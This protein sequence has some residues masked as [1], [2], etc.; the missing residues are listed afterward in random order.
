MEKPIIY[1]ER[2]MNRYV[3]IGVQTQ[4]DKNVEKN[5]GKG[6]VNFRGQQFLIPLFF[7]KTNLKTEI[8]GSERFS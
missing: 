7:A 5:F 4:T 2:D 8:R 6:N 1:I 3:H